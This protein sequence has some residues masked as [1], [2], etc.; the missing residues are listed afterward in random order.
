MDRLTNHVDGERGHPH[1]ADLA[2]ENEADTEG[3]CWGGDDD[4]DD[5]D[6]FLFFLL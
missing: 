4:D 1:D 2:V 6:F 3:H 5:W